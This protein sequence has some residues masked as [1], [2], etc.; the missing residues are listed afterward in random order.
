MT[1]TDQELRFD[2]VLPALKVTQSKQV[3]MAIAAETAKVVGIREKLMMSRLTKAQENASRQDGV[4][5]MDMKISSLTQP[6]V[7]FARVPRG[8]D[9]NAEDGLACDLF[10]VLLSPEHNPALHLQLLARWSRLLR[11]AA[12]CARLR[13]ADDA[14]AI[15]QLMQVEIKTRQRAA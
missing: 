1:Y 3:L 10:A 6:F 8:V 12:F 13:A 2:L 4:C 9:N 5:L 15:R 14:D 7:I 11:D